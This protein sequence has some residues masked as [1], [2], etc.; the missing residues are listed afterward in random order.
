MTSLESVKPYWLPGA[1][2]G[3]A[4]ALLAAAS[5]W[6]FVASC[7]PGGNTCTSDDECFKGEVCKSGVCRAEEATE[8][9]AAVGDSSVGDTADGSGT[10]VS[11]AARA[12]AADVP[13]TPEDASGPGDTC[14]PSTW[15]RDADG[16]GFGDPATTTEA[17]AKPDGYVSDANDCDDGD[18]DVKPRT[19]YPDADGDGYTTTDSE[20][21]CTGTSAPSGYSL[22]KSMP[23][24]CDDSAAKV[25]PSAT[26]V[27]DQADTNCDGKTDN[28]SSGSSEGSLWYVDCDNDDFAAGTTG[29]TRACSK[30][31]DKPLQNFCTFSNADWTK[32]APTNEQRTDC[33]DDNQ[34]AHPGQTMYYTS[35]MNG[36]S[37]VDKW[38]YDCD[39]NV[40][41]RWTGGTSCDEGSASSCSKHCPGFGQPCT[42]GGGGWVG[43]SNPSVKCGAT[44]QWHGC[45]LECKNGTLSC[46]K[47]SKIA[48]CR[49]SANSKTQKCR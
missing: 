31:G 47:N 42:V 35:P 25:H 16:D 23:P 38:D 2:P 17:C 26:E 21:K 36:S 3:T 40:E 10:D 49:S 45:Q 6:V 29:K 28:I 12:D 30:P 41:K 37:R 14:E 22:S 44:A 18:A 34:R 19:V 4:L 24:D 43:G 9:D 7:S 32:K 27:C 5:L 13:A 20:T 15:Y 11:D 1:A 33:N 48:A 39:G 46:S 8:G